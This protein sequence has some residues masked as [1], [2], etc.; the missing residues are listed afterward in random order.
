MEKKTLYSE[1]IR[2]IAEHPQKK[3][4]EIRAAF[5]DYPKCSID[6]SIKRAFNA[7]LLI[8]EVS[9]D[10]FFLYSAPKINEEFKATKPVNEKYLQA[11]KKATELE[12]RGLF[13]RAGVAWLDAMQL[14]LTER[15]RDMCANRR[16]HSLSMGALHSRSESRDSGHGGIYCGT[17]PAWMR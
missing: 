12:G 2:F 1:I 17:L 15:E 9:G 16:R 6:G 14:A 13:N 5:T 8:R 7:G 3:A 10:G 4:A 11:V